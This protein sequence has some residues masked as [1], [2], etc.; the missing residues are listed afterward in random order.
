MCKR[1]L[2]Y[3]DM[4]KKMF[5]VF[6]ILMLSICGFVFWW[7]MVDFWPQ[8]WLE[9]RGEMGDQQAVAVLL[10][11]SYQ[12]HD[13]N[14]VSRWSE[15]LKPMKEPDALFMEKNERRIMYR[16]FKAQGIKTPLLDIMENKAP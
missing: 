6:L 3:L 12:T 7:K 15:R 14:G 13:L 5:F 9:W 16:L 8:D 1:N 2:V 11:K 10:K 4:D